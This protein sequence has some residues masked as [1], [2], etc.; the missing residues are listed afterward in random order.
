VEWNLTEVTVYGKLFSQVSSESPIILKEL[1]G[2]LRTTNR[3]LIPLNA[4]DV[5]SYAFFLHDKIQFEIRDLKL[6]ST[7]ETQDL[8]VCDD[9]ALVEILCCWT[10]FFSIYS[11]LPTALW[12]SGRLSL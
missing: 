4:C 5:I 2:T 12:H 6:K 7:I 1:S 3:F 10:G 11:I 9:G 8:K